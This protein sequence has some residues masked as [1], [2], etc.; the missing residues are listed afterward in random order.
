M[1]DLF[2]LSHTAVPSHLA[3]LEGLGLI[4]PQEQVLMALDGIVLDQTGRR[5]SGPTLHDYCLLTSSRVLLWARDYGRHLCY[6]FPLTELCLVE[7]IGL[8]PIHASLRLAFA[9]PGE[10]KQHF[11]FTL[12]PLVDLPASVSLLRL[13]AN[14]AQEL[15]AQQVSG[16]EASQEIIALLADHV[17]G[18]IANEEQ[19]PPYHWSGQEASTAQ[20]VI[21]PIF[22]HSPNDLPPEQIYKAGRLG[23]VAWDVLYRTIRETESPFNLKASDLR[24]V[25]NTLRALNDLLTTLGNNSTAREIALAYLGRRPG[26]GGD[27]RGG[28]GTGSSEERQTKATNSPPKAEFHEIPLRQRE[29]PRSAPR[30][31]TKAKVSPPQHRENDE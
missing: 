10:E 17:F 2:Y 27:L 7:G 5:V 11:T 23:R 1:L 12:L 14:A 25:T 18:P 4:E 28:G 16:E 26:E 22:Q 19:A 9:A 13:A 29:N 8:D 21:P 24:E 6:A 31:P 20:Q 3:E 15:A 30:S